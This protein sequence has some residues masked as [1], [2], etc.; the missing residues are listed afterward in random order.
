[1]YIRPF[2]LKLVR[3]YSEYSL[4]HQPKAWQL[5]VFAQDY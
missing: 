3:L 2:L 5:L 1:M 4:F